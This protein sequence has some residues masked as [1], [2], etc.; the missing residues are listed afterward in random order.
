MEDTNN[1]NGKTTCK[2]KCKKG[3][4]IYS[5]LHLHIQ[6]CIYGMVSVIT[7]WWPHS[8][9]HITVN[10]QGEESH[11]KIPYFPGIKESTPKW[12][13]HFLLETYESSH[14]AILPLD[15][16][17]D[18]GSSNAGKLSHFN[19][20]AFV[21]HFNITWS[22]C[23]KHLFIYPLISMIPFTLACFSF[24]VLKWWFAH[25][26]GQSWIKY[27]K[28]NIPLPSC[29]LRKNVFQRNQ[30]THWAASHQML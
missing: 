9:S 10:I 19:W 17:S 30:F 27:H 24:D 18:L 20:T 22:T 23:I 15:I 1:K 2:N 25:V 13:W 5:T 6:A 21:S 26:N 11:D 14:R 8:P 29:H 12:F 7:K 16:L 3:L 4:F 28:H